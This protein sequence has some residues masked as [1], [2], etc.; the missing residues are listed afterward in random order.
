MVDAGGWSV[1]GHP[2]LHSGLKVCLGYRKSSVKMVASIT[3]NKALSAELDTETIKDYL[4]PSQTVRRPYRTANTFDH[5]IGAAADDAEP[6][7]SRSAGETT[8]RLTAFENS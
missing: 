7:S 5:T 6:P 4:S 3:V 1:Q 8:K 2:W